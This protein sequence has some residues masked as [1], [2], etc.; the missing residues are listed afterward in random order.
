MSQAKLAEMLKV[1][2]SQV[3]EWETNGDERPSVEKLLEMAKLSPITELRRWL[4]IK[5]GVDLETIRR[6]FHEEVALAI[7]PAA[8]ALTFEVPLFDAKQFRNVQTRS[9]RESEEGIVLPVQILPHPTSTICLRCATCPPWSTSADDLAVIDQA[10]TDADALIGKMSAIFASPL[11]PQPGRVE[12]PRR[13][14]RKEQA[15]LII[16]RLDVQRDNDGF[17]EIAPTWVIWRLVLRLGL[18]ASSKE[19][20]PLSSWQ[21]L[22]RFSTTGLAPIIHSRYQLVGEV[23]AWIKD[24]KGSSKE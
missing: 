10:V 12:S 4:W 21:P 3:A 19:V 20:L 11:P 18:Q 7:N 16:G 2:R 17:S 6:D 1:N 22:D 14:T 8:T 5:A 24:P 15:G 23:V 13:L 9:L